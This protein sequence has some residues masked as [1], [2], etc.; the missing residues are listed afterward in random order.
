MRENITEKLFNYDLS[1]GVD[2]LAGID[3][4]GRGPLAGPVVTAC[5]MMPLDK[6]VD[7]INDSKKVSEKKREEL[8]E[9]IKQISSYS[10]TIVENEKIDEINILEATKYAMKK[11]LDDMPSKPSLVLVDAVKLDS[12]IPVV[13]LIKGD[14][15]SYNIAAA[16][17]L[18]KVTRDRIMREMDALYPEYGFAKNKGYGTKEHIDALIKY[19]PCPIHRYSFIKNFIGKIY[20]NN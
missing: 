3:E 2:G 20:G 7:K 10:I 11:S 18:A 13:P 8:F 9:V 19:G 5:C 15:T 12:D 4:V 17:I 6:M 1:I 14:A 16:S